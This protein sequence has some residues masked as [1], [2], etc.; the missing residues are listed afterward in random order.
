[1]K[2]RQVLILLI[3]LIFP[4]CIFIFLKMFGK[5]RFDVPHMFVE[6]VAS[7]ASE[8]GVDYN[9]PYHVTDSVLQRIG[10]GD[11]RA[12]YVYFADVGTEKIFARVNERY[13]KD[14]VASLRLDPDRESFFRKCIFLLEEPF[15]VVLVDSSG[16][17]RGQYNSRERDEIDRLITE[18]AILIEKY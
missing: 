3:A 11:A 14:P 10:M 5:N 12:A 6:E 13:K 16:V 7:G 18:I 17:I 2:S 8:C 1:M 4:S 15:N 9:L